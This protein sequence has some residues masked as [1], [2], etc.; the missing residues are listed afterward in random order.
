[1][2]ERRTPAPHDAAQLTDIL[3]QVAEG[4]VVAD[5]EGR[6][7]FVND[8]ARRI[9]GVTDFEVAPEEYSQVFRLFTAEGM[10]YPSDELPL[11]RA[12]RRGESVASAEWR[13]RRPDGTEVI[14][15]GSASPVVDETGTQTGAVLSIR[16]VTEAMR[17]RQAME[18]QTAELEA[19]AEELQAQARQLE[20]TQLEVEM[21]N[22]ELQ[23]INAELEARAVEATRARKE[24]EERSEEL[25]QRAREAALLASVGGTLTRGG[26]L[27]EVLARCA[28]IVVEDLDAAFARIWTL[29][30]DDQ[31][32]ELQASAGMYTHLDG[33]HGR[34]PVGALK[35]G[36][37]AAEG[38]PHL[39]NDVP[40]DPR[41]SD[42]TWA[43][44]EGMVAFAGY[45]LL[46]DG[47]VVGVLA[48]F[49]RRALSD[50]AL[51]T[52]GVVADGIALAVQRAAA[53]EDRE[54]LLQVARSARNNAEAAQLLAETARAEAEDANR[55]KSQFLANM[56]H[57]LRTPI[58]AIIGYA[59]LLEVGVAGPLNEKQG[60]Y[61]ERVKSSGRHLIG[62][63]NEILDLAKVEAG[64]LAIERRPA[65]VVE[66]AQ[67]ALSMILPQAAE[68][69]IEV[70]D[71]SCAADTLYLGDENRV[72]QILLNLLSN[73][74]KFTE[75][76]GRITLRCRFVEEADPEAETAGAG[77]WVTI[78]VEDTGA[79]I[80]PEQRRRVFDPFVQVD[81]TSTRREGGTG[82]GLT[83]SRR[84][85]RAMG[86]DLTLRSE[87]GK[88]SRFTLWLP[89][90]SADEPGASWG[91]VGGAP[92]ETPQVVAVV[93]F[94]NDAA[95]LAELGRRVH[96]GVRLVGTTRPGE[97]AAF[98]RREKA[99][100]VV[101]DI[102][103]ESGAAWR[104]A[105]TLLDVPELSDTAVLLLPSIPDA[106]TDPPSPGIDL[107]WIT[108]VPKPF[109]AEQLVQAVSLAILDDDASGVG[110]DFAG[111]NDVLIVD[112]DPDTRR[113]AGTL[114]TQAG[115]LVREAVDGESALAEMRGT[116][117]DVVVLDL[118]MPG[119]NGFGVLE[120]MRADPTLSRVPVVVLTAKTLTRAE[121][122]VLD[123]TTV[124]VLQKGSSHLTDVASL[125]LRAAAHARRLSGRRKDD[126]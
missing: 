76:G 58:N 43:R 57:E 114:L 33:E 104:V 40:N 60:S 100:L 62:L 122:R 35:I 16:D 5:A 32:L 90:G 14:A 49:A 82:L 86:G 101:L 17:A 70:R 37:I 79:G 39:T 115:A 7:T 93:A 94:G 109:T 117:P 125:V 51:G 28:E 120:A 64:E 95:A 21:S 116:P 11:A 6:I 56:S 97:V 36:R 34:V 20:E 83:I 102:S 110:E 12:V 24:A 19:Q 18:E 38:R 13:I 89:S 72:R 27:R 87:S 22:D 77:P 29:D 46:V 3:R 119:L 73:A 1:M 55:A 65:R 84:L 53:E 71:S 8:A 44:R 108:L 106:A 59:D 103:G 113:I 126:G 67:A 92:A 69:G 61:V 80:A 45:P 88:G 15:E 26:P 75:A 78:D 121:R 91:P 107:G 41:V 9:H 99:R 111:G 85:A 105:H 124:R 31:V 96:P 50:A 63:I 74:V 4:V 48:I 23:R 123:R 66:S 42:K 81:A 10:P 47:R 98:A 2:Q 68:K 25:L 54:R 118:M 52:L 112:D 30:E